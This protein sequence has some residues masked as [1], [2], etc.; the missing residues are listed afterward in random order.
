MTTDA[1]PEEMNP[2][3]PVFMKLHALHLLVIG[4]GKVGKEKLDAIL[5]NSPRTRIR[6]VA[7]EVSP[8]VRALVK[9]HSNISLLEMPFAA[10]HLEDIDLVICAIDNPETSQGIR[11][12][13]RKAGILSNFADKPGLCDFYLGSVV[14]KGHVK[15]AISTNG[16]SPTLAKRLREIIGESLPDELHNTVENLTA[17]RA[18]VSGDIEAKIK[19]LNRATDAYRLQHGRHRGW[20][21]VAV[22]AAAVA[23]ML[24]G[25]VLGSQVKSPFGE[26]HKQTQHT[27]R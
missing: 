17:I 8:Q 26:S 1:H 15:I 21:I 13:T 24:L 20:H 23:L 27:Q 6:L 3:F 10:H 2:L 18:R 5:A 11:V 16:K 14:Q 25:H 9:T 22:A 4:G 12:I 19:V 7:K